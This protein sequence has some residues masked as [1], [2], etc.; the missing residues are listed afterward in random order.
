MVAGSLGGVAEFA[1]VDVR[2]RDDGAEATLA[3]QCCHWLDSFRSYVRAVGS[4]PLPRNGG[5]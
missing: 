1:G 4:R 5:P 3:A 2:S